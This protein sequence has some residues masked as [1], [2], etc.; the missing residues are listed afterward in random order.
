M[1]KTTLILG[2]ALALFLTTSAAQA[3]LILTLTSG[4]THET[5]VDNAGAG[6]LS[7]GGTLSTVAD[8]NPL[9]GVIGYT[10]SIATFSVNITTGISKPVIGPRTID[11]SS[12]NVSGV[13]AGNLFIFLLDTDFTYATSGPRSLTSSIGGTTMGSVS[14]KGGWNSLNSESFFSNINS[15]GPFGPVAFAGS[16]TG[17]ISPTGGSPF[18]IGEGVWITHTAAG[19][20]SSFNFE[21]KAS[22]GTPMP[23]P[24]TATLLLLGLAGLAC[25]RR[26][27][28]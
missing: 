7:S 11:L 17:T 3:D 16:A 4:L 27:R 28:T 5:V 6:V 23:E 1:R 24:A 8:S 15:L 19:Q 18:A 9:V 20:I 21:T 2:A 14:A 25:R 13:A 22:D 26:R 10:G 12:V